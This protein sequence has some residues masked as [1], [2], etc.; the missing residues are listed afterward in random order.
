[1]EIR[2][3]DDAQKWF[4]EE[5]GLEAGASVRFTVRYGGSGLQPGF[6]LGLSVEEPENPSAQAESDG[7]TYFVES[8]DEWYFDGHDLVVGYDAALDEPEYGYEK[9]K[10]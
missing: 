2:I 6:S 9:E 3:S 1:M 4:Y 10:A 7:I 5:M 8:D